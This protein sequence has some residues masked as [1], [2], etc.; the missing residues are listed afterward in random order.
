MLV[1][2]VTILTVSVSSSS[3]MRQKPATGWS[4]SSTSA[5]QTI[6]GSNSLAG[7]SFLAVVSQIVVGELEFRGA[8]VSTTSR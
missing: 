4:E 6:C 1:G 8:V 7:I 2:V 5:D 3:P